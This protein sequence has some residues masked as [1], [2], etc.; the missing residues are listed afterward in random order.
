[1]VAPAVSVLYP[2]KSL[3]L[4]ANGLPI[5]HRDAKASA[6]DVGRTLINDALN[7]SHH[8]NQD[9][10]EWIFGQ[11]ILRYLGELERAQR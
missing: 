8:I 7:Y 6:I 5:G 1:M 10:A 4:D 11:A 3:A 2:I 9:D